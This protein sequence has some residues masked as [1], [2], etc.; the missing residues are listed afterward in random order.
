MPVLHSLVFASQQSRLVHDACLAELFFS[1][2]LLQQLILYAE[3]GEHLFK[4]PILVL[5]GLKISHHRDIHA[6][7]LGP[8]FEKRGIADLVLAAKFFNGHPTFSLAQNAHH[9]RVSKSALSHQILFV[10]DTEKILLPKS[11]QKRREYLLRHP[12]FAQC[13]NCF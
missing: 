3:F 4:P 5:R 1:R 8:P 2:S 6:A 13:E 12:F 9:A 10:H 7:K 11:P